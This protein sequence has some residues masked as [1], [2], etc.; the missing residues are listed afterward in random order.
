MKANKFRSISLVSGIFAIAAAVALAQQQFRAPSAEPGL[1]HAEALSL[2]FRSVAK[3]V[4]PAVVS[5]ETRSKA[6]AV[7]QSLGAAPFEDEFFK[8]F[9]GEDFDFNQQFRQRQLPPQRGSGSGF[10]IDSSG[11][12][13]TNAHV[14][15]GAERVIV[16]LEDG[17]ELNATEWHA[18]RWSDVAIVRVDVDEPLP[19]VPLG[20]SDQMEIGDWV[21]A[22]G[23]PFDV[24]T[25]VTSG[26]ISAKGRS[27]G[28]NDRESYL[29][30]DAAINPGNSGGPLVNLHGEVVGINTAI[31]TRSGGYDGVGFAIPVNNARWVSEQLIAKGSVTRP[32]LG[33]QLQS[34]TAE[35]R[36]TFGVPNGHG[37]LVAHVFDGTPA[38]EAGIEEGDVILE[39]AGKEI[40][41]SA[42]LQGV[43]EHLDVGE[44]YPVTVLRNGKETELQVTLKEMPADYSSAARRARQYGSGAPQA[45]EFNELGLEIGALDGQD[46]EQFSIPEDAE[47]V[48][49][50]SVEPNSPAAEAHIRAGD[51][52]EK[53]GN[54][55][56]TSPEE[57]ER[58]VAELSLEQGIVMLV[59][60][61]NSTH[62]VVVK[63]VE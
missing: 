32:Y 15:E 39:V 10:I 29:Q 54:Q 12:I 6:V 56:V 62:F 61:G 4:L 55:H 19:S 30:T 57:F 18:D 14:V 63:S 60:R 27:A 23:N 25:T 13:M 43:I 22:L 8:R 31:S 21:L 52:I 34:F 33:V 17:R 37:T 40:K 45:E 46:A 11:V 5:I 53:A 42:H 51:V 49:V 47:G 9:F 41:H 35:L 48:L 3:A 50:T 24:G 28:I 1:A 44:T 38:A 16:K 59:R 20:D 36:E 26:I 58:A 2:T 7:N